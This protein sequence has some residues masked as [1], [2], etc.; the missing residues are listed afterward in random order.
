MNKVL[1]ISN[2]CFSKTDSNGRT[3]GNFFLGWDKS[4]LAQ[5]YIQ[6]SQPD[7]DYC[8]NYFRVT[9]AQAL[10]ALKTGKCNGG[11]VE[12][13]QEDSQKSA[14]QGASKSKRNALTMTARNMVWQAGMWQKCGFWQWVAEFA[15]DV[16]LL[17][18]G[19]CA[20]MYRLAAKVAKKHNAKLVIY[21][22][23][24][25]YFK[26]FDY[27]RSAGLAKLFY[28]FFRM[29]LRKA[30]RKAYRAA[31]YIIYLCDS[32]KRSYDQEFSAPSETIYTASELKAGATEKNNPV[33]TVSYCGN[34]GL[35]RHKGLMDIAQVLQKI[36]KDIYVDVYGRAGENV[37][38][39]FSGCSGIRYHGL[40]PYEQVKSVMYGSDLILHTE[41]F[42]DFYRE[43]LK[44]AF[45]TK[46]A[47]SLSCGT[48]FLLYAPENLACSQYLTEHKAAYV[49]SRKEDLADVLKQLITEPE[50]RSKYI[51]RALALAEKNHRAETNKKRFQ[52]ILRGL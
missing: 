27:F 35:D 23:E 42:D 34:L 30:L 41:S 24:A 51:A 49:V 44:F 48:C 6:N 8:E 50:A 22:S 33:F 31:A 32:L 25:Y 5:F 20:F 11:V 12:K 15:P 3:L 52:D 40:I 45:S 17:Q 38:E 29:D 21:N 46:I 10:S 16:V 7:F 18:A 28:P 43:D 1:V 2:N 36:S 4:C 9:D 26:N 14:G 39:D 13:P 19:D 37:I 47:D